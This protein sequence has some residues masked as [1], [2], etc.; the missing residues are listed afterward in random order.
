MNVYREA[1]CTVTPKPLLRDCNIPGLR[2]GDDRQ[3]DF[4]ASAVDPHGLPVLA[5]VTVISAI[6][7]QGWPH[8]NAASVDGSSFPAAYEDKNGVKQIQAQEAQKRDE[9][10]SAD[11]LAA[12]QIEMVLRRIY[13]L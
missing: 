10:M 5:D 11:S 6:D 3:L 9:L 4:R 8:R 13:R 2:R 7:G 1:G 12:G